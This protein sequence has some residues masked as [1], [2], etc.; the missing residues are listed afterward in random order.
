MLHEEKKEKKTEVCS[1]S[2][3]TVFRQIYN[4]LRSADIITWR[5]KLFVA[6]GYALYCGPVRGKIAIIAKHKSRNYCEKKK[7][8]HTHT[9]TH[10]H[11]QT[12]TYNL[13]NVPATWRS[14]T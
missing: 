8:T 2:T 5:K 10:T 6:K 11:T 12:H 9:H 13:K 7:N 1:S 3:A 14:V 4:C